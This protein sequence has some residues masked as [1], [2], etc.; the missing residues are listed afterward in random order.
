[1]NPFS[2]YSYLFVPGTR[3][4][5]YTKALESGAGAV[6]I[7]LEDAV[8]AADKPKAREA[9]AQHLADLPPVLIR[10]NG[11]ETEWFHDDLMMCKH[12]KVAG[13]MLPKAEQAGDI[14]FIATQLGAEIPIYPLIETAKGMSSAGDIARSRNVKQL[15]FGS[16][17]FQLDM[18]IAD[19]DQGLLY[20]RSHLVLASRLA[21]IA[22]PIDG[23]TVAV[24]D[25][26]A[27]RVDAQRSR[28]LGF[29]GKLCI[30][31]NQIGLVNSAF[32]PSEQEIAWAKRIVDSAAT[33]QGAAVLVEGQ[34]VDKP[35][36]LRAQA[37]LNRPSKGA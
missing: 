27:L 23:V 3:P 2:A 19:D 7:D 14:E 31:P 35:V 36:L 11:I 34:L 21:N 30:H 1:M 28:G 32:G 25:Q 17:D 24:N 4:D 5:R 6:I 9:V 8:S 13:I 37:I 26:N 20:F 10:I 29:G 12:H 18:G 33:A 22:A 15:A 16:I